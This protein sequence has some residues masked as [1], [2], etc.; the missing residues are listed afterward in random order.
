MTDWLTDQ[1]A[2]WVLTRTFE[3]CFPP[4]RRSTHAR[5]RRDPC[6]LARL[7]AGDRWYGVARRRLAVAPHAR[8]SLR[9]GRVLATA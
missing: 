4:R 6:R 2:K 8:R 3:I 1:R 7:A 9:A 5:A